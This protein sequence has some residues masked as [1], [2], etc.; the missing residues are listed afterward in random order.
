MNEQIAQLLETLPHSFD[1]KNLDEHKSLKIYKTPEGTIF[2][3]IHEPSSPVRFEVRTGDHL[4]KLL[5]EKYE[6]IMRS[7]N[8]SPRNWVEVITSGQLQ[9]DEYLDLIR[10]S[11]YHS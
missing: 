10:T 2:L 9:D 11:Y 6:S 7:N 8:M 5:T 1:V 3:I 4:R